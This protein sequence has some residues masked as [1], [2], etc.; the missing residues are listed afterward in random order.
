MKSIKIK[1]IAL[2]NQL[3]F[4]NLVLFFSTIAYKLISE[5]NNINN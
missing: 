3:Q 1:E 2:F 4:F 5:L